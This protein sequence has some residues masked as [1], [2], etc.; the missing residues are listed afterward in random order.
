M[1]IGIKLYL[2]LNVD[3]HLNVD[4]EFRKYLRKIPD[5]RLGVE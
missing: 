1:E 2:H 4:Q 5:S 3:H